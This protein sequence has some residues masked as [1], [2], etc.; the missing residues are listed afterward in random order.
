MT[1][2]DRRHFLKVTSAA[3][4]ALA[5]A[6]TA[7]GRDTDAAGQSAQP[8]NVTISS[9]SYTPADYPIQAKRFS[10]VTLRDRF[11]KPQNHHQRHGHHS[12]ARAAADRGRQRARLQRQRARS[13]HPVARGTSRSQAAGDRRQARRRTAR[14]AA[15]RQR[16]LRGRG[17][18]LPRDRQTR[19]DRQ[20]RA[21]PRMRCIPSSRRRTRRSPAANGTPSIVCSCTA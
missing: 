21:R 3:A 19:P 4:G 7:H 18:L 17:R 2:I 15:R 16:R 1:H 6:A 8:A 12:A 11:W 13:G 14:A 20:R 10:Q 5:H 9:V